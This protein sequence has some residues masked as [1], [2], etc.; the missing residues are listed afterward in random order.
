MGRIEIEM[1]NSLMIL[2]DLKAKK[3]AKNLSLPKKEPMNYT[4]ASFVS[5]TILLHVL[6]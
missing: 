3:I 4:V 1:K 6:R 2:D 5:Y